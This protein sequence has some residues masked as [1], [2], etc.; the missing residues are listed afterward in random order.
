MSTDALRQK[1]IKLPNRFQ[2]AQIIT[3]DSG[4]NNFIIA[5]KSQTTFTEKSDRR[6]TTWQ[7]SFPVAALLQHIMMQLLINATSSNTPLTSRQDWFEM[8]WTDFMGF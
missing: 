1:W 6:N 2:D 3:I 4:A 7:N 5:S 8:F